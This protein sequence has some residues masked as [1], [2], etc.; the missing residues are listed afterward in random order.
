MLD[1]RSFIVIGGA[2]ALSACGGGNPVP[3]SSGSPAADDGQYGGSTIPDAALEATQDALEPSILDNTFIAVTN[4]PPS[5]ATRAILRNLPTVAAQGTPTMLGDPG[6]CIAQSYGYGLGAYTAARTLG[7]AVKWDASDPNYQPSAAWLYQWQHQVIDKGSESCP[8]GSA[9]T[10]YAQRLVDAGSPNTAQVPYNPDGYST[11]TSMC[12]YIEGIDLGRP[13][14]SE[15]NLIVGSYK[16]FLNILNQKSV[17]LDT[18]RSLLRHGHA[19]AFTGLVPV[20]YGKIA[21]ALTNGVYYAPNGF[22]TGSGHGQVIFGF[23]DA[24]GKNGAFLVQ[25][26]FGSAWN[27]GG[28]DDLGRNGRIWYDYDA[29]F[30]G[31]SCAM[32]MWPSTVQPVSGILLDPQFTAAPSGGVPELAVKNVRIVRPAEPGS[33]G[34]SRLV[35]VSHASNAINI[36]KLSVTDPAGK[37]FSAM[38]DEHHRVGYTYVER[39]D[40]AEFMQGNYQL[41][42]DVK[43]EGVPITYTGSVPAPLA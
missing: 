27:P 33:R 40:G 13:W 29:F 36:R 37:T 39:A 26:S 21:P 41:S 9:S 30:A 4:A 18:F 10:P 15:A 12:S 23:D 3:F 20:G 31:Q 8:K 7:G 28:S 2:A 25:N 1:R 16:R 38:M 24:K 42:Y 11:V 19:I 35:V 5:S 22:I 32:I 14:P 43:R 6:S 34:P 17:F